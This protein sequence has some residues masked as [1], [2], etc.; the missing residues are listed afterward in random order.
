MPYYSPRVLLVNDSDT[1]GN[2]KEKK[3][4]GL[5]WKRTKHYSTQSTTAHKALQHT[6]H[7]NA[8]I[9]TTHKVLQHTMHYNT[10]STTTHNALQHTKHYNAQSTARC[11]ATSC[12]FTCR[13]KASTPPRLASLSSDKI[14]KLPSNPVLVSLG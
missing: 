13:K 11:L 12:G 5:T 7:Y 4:E 8:Q 9:T 1:L 3:R 14:M 10:Q 6:M 2:G